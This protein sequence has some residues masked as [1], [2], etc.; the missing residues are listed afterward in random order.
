MGIYITGDIIQKERTKRG[1]S[2]EELSY[3][4]CTT[5]TL[6]NIENEKQEPGS[7]VARAL[8]ERM[9]SVG[10][11]SA[12]LYDTASDWNIEQMENEL[13]QAMWEKESERVEQ[14]L[15]QIENLG[16][17]YDVLDLQY[18]QAAKWYFELEKKE[19]Q[20][21]TKKELRDCIRQTIPAFDTAKEEHTYLLTY[22]E[23]YLIYLLYRY[24]N[25]VGEKETAVRVLNGLWK[26][27]THHYIKNGLAYVGYDKICLELA[28]ENIRRGDYENAQDLL[29]QTENYYVLH[30]RYDKLPNTAYQKAECMV[31]QEKEDEAKEVIAASYYHLLAYGKETQAKDLRKRAEEK[32][33]ICF[34]IRYIIGE[35]TK[36]E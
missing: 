32:L 25:M 20:D 7:K 17:V 33:G 8:L 11:H 15:R 26:S 18:L 14:L 28:G 6:S 31:C 23:S 27:I 35:V 13:L 12:Y 2:Q 1:L 29:K 22:I 30:G 10:Y 21:E 24:E 19:L 9:G 5:A 34:H 3:G 4:I 36:D 16:L